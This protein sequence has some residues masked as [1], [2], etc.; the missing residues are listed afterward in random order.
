MELSTANIGALITAI[1]MRLQDVWDKFPSIMD[2]VGST[3]Q[4]NSTTLV[5]PWLQEF[6][7][8]RRFVGDRKYQ[9][10]IANAF[11]FT[12]EI[13]E[14][15]AELDRS[16]IEDDQWGVWL[17][18]APSR[19]ALACKKQP[20]KLISELIEQQAKTFDGVSFFSSA[21]PVDFSDAASATQSNQLVNAAISANNIQVLRAQM[22]NLKTPDG[23]PS[24]FVP[25]T[26]M[27]PPALE[28]IAMQ[29]AH[30]S[31]YPDLTGG[32]GGVGSTDNV[33]KGLYNVGP[34]V[35]LTARSSERLFA[36]DPRIP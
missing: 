23:L 18:M 35:T 33:M 15:T 1:D 14:L 12:P 21:H 24:G 4:C 28:L 27:V 20:D 9:N 25:D 36:P 31:F 7:Q 34:A 29:V 3:L 5:V 6:P 2:R 30:G 19:I 13:W 17:N 11:T 8:L 10:F 16:A 26:I 22:M 32:V